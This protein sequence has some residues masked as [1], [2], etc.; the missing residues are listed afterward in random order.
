MLIPVLILFLVV[1]VIIIFLATLYKRLDELKHKCDCN[2]RDLDNRISNIANNTGASQ[3]STIP[4]SDP[5]LYQRVSKLTLH[6]GLRWQYPSAE[7]Q[8]FLEP[9]PKPKKGKA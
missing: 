9:I 3:Y 4:K 2:L 7:T 1:M 6:L 5:T 8:A